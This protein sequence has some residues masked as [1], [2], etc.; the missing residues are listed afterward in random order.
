MS[1]LLRSYPF[2]IGIAVFILALFL[3]WGL[4][5]IFPSTPHNGVIITIIG[6]IISAPFFIGAYILYRSQKNALNQVLPRSR[7]GKVIFAIGIVLILASLGGAGSLLSFQGKTTETISVAPKEIA[8]YQPPYTTYGD[9]VVHNNQPDKTEFDVWV[10]L[11]LHDCSIDFSHI[12]MNIPNSE[13]ERVPDWG[14]SPLSSEF[15]LLGNNTRGQQFMQYRIRK[16]VP[17][18]SRSFILIVAPTANDFVG[19][20]ASIAL[21][22]GG[23]SDT[24][25][26]VIGQGD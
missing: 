13:L 18:E 6:L 11:T 12:E 22:I 7:R 20:N 26:P 23:Y 21:S 17:S 15:A 1:R 3:G 8:I 14:S 25:G 2:I 4:P 9:F 16:L 24:P 5:M 10:V 19:G